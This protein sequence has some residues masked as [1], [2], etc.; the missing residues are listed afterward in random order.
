M[1]RRLFLLS[2]FVL[3]TLGA[4]FACEG[5]QSYVYSA[6]KYDP[7]ADCLASYSS[8]ETVNGAGAGS[9]C[10]PACLMVGADLYV[11]TMCP[12]LPT[13]ATAIPAGE[14]ACASAL[15]AAE[16]GGT[17]DEPPE[18]GTEDAAE[19]PSAED[20][21]PPD[22]EPDAEE[23]DAADSAPPIADAADAG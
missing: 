14:P 22:A 12:P 2:C 7:A 4:A 11:S 20:A 6:Q 3:A 9:M 10:A 21:T 17:C 23:P 5:T 8:I 19:E 15:A 1:M 16:R 18:A 13:I